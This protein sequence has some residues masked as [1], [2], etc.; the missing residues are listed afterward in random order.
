MEPLIYVA[1]GLAAGLLGSLV[2][3]GGGVLIVPV[4]SLLMGVP[5][6][7]AVAA[8]LVAVV[9]T[10]SSATIGFL[11][12]GLVN[13]RLGF[14]LET[15]MTLGAVLGGLTSA[16]FDQ[17]TLSAVF[18]AVLFVMVA[19]LF[20]R[21]DEPGPED[22][23]AHGDG[24]TGGR[25]SARFFDPRLGGPTSY[26]VRRLPL[27]LATSLVAGNVSG[28]LGIGGGV[29][30]VP[31]MTMLMGVPMK[32]AAA[33]SSFMIGLTAVAGASV[34]YVHGLVDPAVAG[35]VALGAMVGAASGAG[36][37]S[38]IGGS[39][40]RKLLGVVLFVLAVQMA[41]SAGGIRLR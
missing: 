12:R 9:A 2:G 31:T 17:R 40:L 38:R 14:T 25:L 29:I 37:S 32:A 18:A 6:H 23:S 39:G 21:K 15:T 34:Y 10:S 22:A 16:A 19:S 5:I 27:G 41:L 3:L 4:L 33:T 20:W 36:L 28:L 8:S 11:G 26:S 30:N 7:E 1:V 13:L 24:G 35:P